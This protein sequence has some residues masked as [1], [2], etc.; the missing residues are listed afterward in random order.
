M[1]YSNSEEVNERRPRWEQGGELLARLLKERHLEKESEEA[2][3]PA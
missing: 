2:F 1:N 3:C